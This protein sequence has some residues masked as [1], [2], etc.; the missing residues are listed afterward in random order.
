MNSDGRSVLCIPAHQRGE[1]NAW[2]NRVPHDFYH[3][4]EYHLL[5][6]QR[7][8]GCAFLA[9]YGDPSGFV[10]WPYLLIRLSSMPGLEFTDR[11]DVTSVYGYPGP[12]RHGCRTGGPYLEQAFKAVCELWR[13]QKVVSAFSRANPLL[14]NVELLETFGELI[15]CGQTVSVNL[16]IPLE[17]SWANYRRS[18][19]Y[20]I[21]KGQQAGL[22]FSH[23][24]EWRRLDEFAA[25]YAETM[26]RRGA[27]GRYLFDKYYF[28]AL[29]EALGSAGHL[30]LTLQGEGIAAGG[31]FTECCGIVQYHLS[32]IREEYRPLAPAKVLLDGARVWA[33]ARGNHVLHL[34][35]GVG[36]AEDSLFLFKSGLSS[37]RHAFFVW[38][39]ILDPAG[40]ELLAEARARFGVAQGLTPEYPGFFPPYRQPLIAAELPAEAA[41]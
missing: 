22:R 26:R 16:D 36:G 8:E 9:V 10:A 4:A 35:G 31:I 17:Q 40:Y 2:M 27:S 39:A 1:W 34:G 11:C 41:K 32:A 23:D 15:P 7:G 29:H 20:E 30:L 38:R 25:L 19:R 28:A 21:R 14:G 12:L 13:R 6:E 24:P 3:R 33:K 5:A 37:R 18:H